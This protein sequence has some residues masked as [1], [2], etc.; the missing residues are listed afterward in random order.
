ME[1]N[2]YSKRVTQDDSLP[3]A[4]AMF[5]AIGLTTEDF[6]KPFVGIASTGYE[7]NPCNMHLNDLALEVKQGT[8]NENLVGLIYNTIGVS[9]GI[10]MGTPGM[11][12]SLPSRDVIADSM[13][14]VVEG[15]SYDALVTVVGCDK[16]MPGALMAMLRTNRPGVLVYGGTIASGCHKGKKLDVVSAF[17][18]WGQ[19]VAGKIDEEEYQNVIEKACPGAGACGGMYTANTMASAIEALGMSLPYNSSNPA[20]GKEKK[21]ESIKAGE[22]V[23]LLLEKDIKPKDIV[24]KK[25]LENAIRLVTIMGGSTNAVLHFLAIARTAEVDFTL[26]DFQRI[27]DTTPFLAD[28]KPSGQYLMEDIHAIGGIPA[29]L[30]YLLKNGLLHGDCLTVTGKTLAENLENVP[31]LKADQQIIKTLENPIKR[32]RTFKN[33]ERK[34][35]AQRSCSKNHRKRRFSI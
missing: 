21:I 5:H 10:S 20:L 9:D 34:F 2:K 6:K 7:G 15:M 28:L 1:L 30:K 31:D 33:T 3:A 18:A 8:K 35:I 16:N 13:E 22:V 27:S 19:K 24:T 4:K 23:S 32:N 25:A 14:T 17:E 26:A 29:V 11:R 12:Y